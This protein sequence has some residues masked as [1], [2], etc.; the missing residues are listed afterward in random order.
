MTA[1]HPDRPTL[2]RELLAA[3]RDFAASPA[4]QTAQAA[5][6]QA[7]P[8][9]LAQLEPELLGVYWPLAGEFDPG[10]LPYPRALPFARREPA[11]MVFRRWDGSAPAAQ[12]ECGIA[13][14]S[15]AVAVPDVVL[16][17]CVGFTREG[18]RLGYGGG[19]FD[20][21]MAAHPGV[22][23]IGLAWSGSETH[24]AVE[25]HDRAL[26]LILTERELVT[27]D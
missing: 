10:E 26:T 20:R 7:L 17:P 11:E 25:A 27:P 24:F 18:F 23:A 13:T 2:R 6:T 5:L 3:R 12:D 15:G 14:S 16:V 1:A 21:W 19:Y 4:F 8:E 9:L 22:T